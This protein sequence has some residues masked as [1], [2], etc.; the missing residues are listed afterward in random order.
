MILCI[1]T[2]YH[3][4]ALPCSPILVAPANGFINCTGPQ[5]TEESCQF[6]C[7]PGY[8]LEG[9]PVRE[10]TN[11][12][13]WSGEYPS[14][15]K[16]LCPL[17]VPITN[18]LIIRPCM[19]QFNSTCLIACPN[20]YSLTDGSVIYEQMCI[21]DGSGGVQWTNTRTCQRKYTSIAVS[22]SKYIF[23]KFSLFSQ[24]MSKQRPLYC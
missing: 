2:C 4:T 16:Q 24:S 15:E 18:Y 19:R 13:S 21:A 3:L 11:D 9:S 14:C 23:S 6:T 20:G 10:C 5:V 12:S 1:A 8:Q 7:Q 17:L 22:Y